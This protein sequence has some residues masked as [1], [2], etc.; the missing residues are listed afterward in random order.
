MQGPTGSGKTL[1]AKTLSRIVG[2]PFAQADATSLTQAGY[3]G[4]DVE[5]MLFKLLQVCYSSCTLPSFKRVNIG[6]YINIGHI[7]VREIYKDSMKAR[8]NEC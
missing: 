4:E 2:V 8:D 6:V 5:S 1:L 3:V 7:S